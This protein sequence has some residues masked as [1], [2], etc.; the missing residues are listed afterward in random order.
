[1]KG[2]CSWFWLLTVMSGI[3]IFSVIVGFFGCIVDGVVK[4]GMEERNLWLN[5]E[6]CN[7]YHTEIERTGKVKCED[8]FR[9]HGEF[10]RISFFLKHLNAEL[11]RVFVPMFALVY[12]RVLLLLVVSV[13]GFLLFMYF[14]GS[15][16]H[17]HDGSSYRIAN[18]DPERQPLLEGWN[19]VHRIGSF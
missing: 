2:G 18:L 4:S 8:I 3:L 9:L 1:M 16:K 12:D 15:T 17:R 6:D 10:N 5:V 7:K 14:F 19:K 13:G 11:P